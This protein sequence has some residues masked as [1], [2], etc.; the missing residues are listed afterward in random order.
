MSKPTDI[1]LYNQI[2]EKVFK[3][4]PKHSAYRSGI[5]V[6]RYKEAFFKKHGNN[7]SYR[8]NKKENEGL[9]RWFKE[10]WKNQRGQ[11]GYQKKGDI[12]RPTKKIT[13]KTPATY[14]ELTKKQLTSSKKEKKETGQVK[15]FDK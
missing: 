13:N 6:R 10:N 14:Q 8:G 1:N 5:L 3:E 9:S 4:I 2:K 11:S 12:Y 7:N 15:K